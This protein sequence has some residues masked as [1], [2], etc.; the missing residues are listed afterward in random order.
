MEKPSHIKESLF[1]VE[2][3]R[4]LGALRKNILYILLGTVG[5]A[6]FAVYFVKK[7]ES[8]SWSATSKIIRYSK[9]ISQSSDVPYQFQDFNYETALET[10]RSR[11]NLAELIERLDLND[12][13]SPES[14]FSKFEIKRGRNSDIV[15]IIFTSPTQAL[16]AKGANELSKIFLDKFN[17]I[18]NA[19]IERIYDYYDESRKLK[20][21]SYQ[22]AK[23]D[24]DDFLSKHGLTSLENTL[25][26]QYALLGK[27]KL[28]EQENKTD[29]MEYNTSISEIIST[30][31]SLP[32]E[33]KLRYAIRSANKKA[34]EL[35]FKELERQ[36]QVYTEEH[37]KIMMLRSEVKQLEETIKKAAAVEPDEVTYG[38][39]PM[40][41]ELRI[42]LGKTKIQYIAAQGI[43]KSLETQ[44][45]SVQKYLAKLTILKQE[46]DQLE[47]TKN[48][49]QEQLKMVSNRLYD[50]KVSIGS[51]KEDFKLFEYAKT[52][53]YPNPSYKKTV[54]ILLT[55]VGLFLFTLFIV[56]REVLDKKIK[57]KFDLVTRFGIEDTVALPNEVGFSPS[58]RKIFS[59]LANRIIGN[60]VS[61]PH[62]ITL[63]AD[64]SP[65]TTSG[66]T[67][68][69]L[70][71][72]VYQE[73]KI[74]HI[75]SSSTS[76]DTLREDTIDLVSPLDTQNYTPTKSKEGI[77]TLYWEIKD[78]FAVFIP[79]KSALEESFMV[80][81]SLDY[82]YIVID[83]PAYQG[84]EHLIPMFVQCTDTFLLYTEFK[85]SRRNILNDFM[86]HIEENHINK[87]KGVIIDVHKYFL[88]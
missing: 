84:A 51:S 78:D 85:T 70:E 35:K 11:G 5:F 80:L 64:I 25:Q 46:Y 56:V 60:N 59:F 57:T 87:I 48:E 34:L 14:L 68:M 31:K 38:T 9:Q 21:I 79:N 13:A 88:S 49:T 3:R 4:I 71:H 58:N 10:I 19:A 67:K 44:M 62:I 77:D 27:L 75:Q 29:I 16:A 86:L 61:F 30:I 24:M 7:D 52:P 42:I 73:H 32:E 74:L 81:K 17:T 1:L 50:L 53:H 37:P 15:E 36:K 6:L 2:P 72:L 8:K 18:Q 47:R 43:T 23:K 83:V 12:T 41:S 33:V 69:F 28:Q 63:G 26:I 45:K 20:V 54:V 39:N 55:F 76:L 22:S 82:N 65:R 66:V 40:K